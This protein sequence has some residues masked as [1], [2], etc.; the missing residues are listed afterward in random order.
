[1]LETFGALGLII[2]VF[3]IFLSVLWIILPFTVS[4]I[5][6]QQKKTHSLLE[7]IL[8]ELETQNEKKSDDSV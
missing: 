3:L 6:S 8:L 4:N 1:M 2:G 5:L 7:K